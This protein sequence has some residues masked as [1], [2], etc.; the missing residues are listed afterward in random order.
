LF[1]TSQTK[2]LATTKV[3]EQLE[4]LMT[5]DLIPK[6]DTKVSQ[7]Y[8]SCGNSYETNTAYARAIELYKKLLE[9]NPDHAQAQ[10]LESV[11]A[12]ATVADIKQQGAKEI[13]PPTR[14]ANTEDGSTVVEIQNTSPRK[15]R[16]IFSGST[17]K[18]EELEP[19]KDCKIYTYEESTYKASEPCPNKGPKK[20]YTLAPGQYKIA[21]NFT[22]IPGETIE[23]WV[24]DWKLEEGA[25]YGTCFVIVHGLREKSQNPQRPE[26]RKRPFRTG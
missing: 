16:I 26:N 9:Q 7:F 12:R 2:S 10:K 17:P 25:E 15:M 3:C 24:A 22:E 8:L 19:C 14:I 11:L 13:G 18:F 6:L 21:V 1:Q 20:R 4:N 5:K 23:S